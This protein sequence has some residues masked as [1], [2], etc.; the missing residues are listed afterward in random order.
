MPK[1]VWGSL[2][3]IKVVLVLD[4]RFIVYVG[5]Q[6]F[7]IVHYNFNFHKFCLICPQMMKIPWTKKMNLN[8]YWYKNRYQLNKTSVSNTFIY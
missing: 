4:Q 8:L 1:V 5:G 3:A 7:T 6:L 2:T